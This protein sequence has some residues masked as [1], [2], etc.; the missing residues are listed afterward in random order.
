[1]ESET[2]PRRKAGPA[3][4]LGTQRSD[5]GDV[6][7][8]L[9]LGP[10]DQVELHALAFRE[11]AEAAGADGRE[12]HEHVL[13]RV[14]GDE[15]EALGVVEPFHRALHAALGGSRRTRYAHGPRPTAATAATGAA[16]AA[17]SAVPTAAA[18]VSTV[19]TAATAATVPRTRTRTRALRRLEAVAT[20]H[21][22]ARGGHERHFGLAPAV[23][24]H[25]GIHL[26]VGPP[27]RR[28]SSRAPS[29]GRGA[30][31]LPL[32]AAVLAT[33]GFVREP[34]LAIERLLTRGEQELITAIHAGDAL[35]LSARHDSDE[36]PE[37]ET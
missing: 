24:A 15:A 34:A 7:R 18:A 36:P 31:C 5:L 33:G 12:V 10:R 17:V 19:P 1:M 21:R 28:R 25:R 2:A 32:L 30:S 8:L 3:S 14:R 13:A 4:T 23:R 26:L 6:R 35:V 16:A 22:S 20:Q 37:T 27:V 29:A 9:A 11:R